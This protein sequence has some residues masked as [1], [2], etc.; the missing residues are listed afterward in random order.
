MK[1]DACHLHIACFHGP[2]VFP[3]G[4]ERTESCSTR[5]NFHLI[6]IEIIAQTRIF[7]GWFP[8]VFLSTLLIP[9]FLVTARH[10]F[11][12]A[13]LCIGTSLRLTGVENRSGELFGL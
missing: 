11:I 12:H 7:Q 2:L 4:P 10:A 8:I 9:I 13:R 6:N 1:K 3:N 5:L